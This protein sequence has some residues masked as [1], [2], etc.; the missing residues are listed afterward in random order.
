M[1]YKFRGLRTDG[2]GW[3]YGDLNQH[4]VHYDCQIIENGVILYS[5]VRESVGMLVKSFNSMDYYIGDIGKTKDEAALTVVL[6]WI[7]EY[8]MCAWLTVSEY[9]D[10]VA[11]IGIDLDK[12]M[13]WTYAFEN[14]A[15]KDIEIIDNI[16]E[17][18][19]LIKQ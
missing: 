17:N 10:C 7:K 9:K 14:D 6:C 19:E 15:C 5:V 8:S 3:V 11:G 13:F 1:Q 4:P 12:V 2:K 18:P 16:H